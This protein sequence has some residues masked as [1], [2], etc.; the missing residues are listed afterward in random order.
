VGVEEGW[1]NGVQVFPQPM[2]EFAT[3]SITPAIN[4][5]QL[6]VCDLQGRIVYQTMVPEDGMVN[7]SRAEVSIA[8]LYLLTIQ[9]PTG[10]RAHRKLLV[11]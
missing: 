7:L 4:G 8:G 9:S 5:T 3:V 2:H 6:V 11:Q 1:A 10:K